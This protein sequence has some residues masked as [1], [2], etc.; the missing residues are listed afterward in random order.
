MLNRIIDMFTNLLETTGLARLDPSLSTVVSILTIAAALISAVKLGIRRLRIDTRQKPVGRLYD[1]LYGHSV[2]SNSEVQYQFLSYIPPRFDEQKTLREL[3]REIKQCSGDTRSKAEVF[4]V[5]GDPACGKTTTMRYL[6]C[7]LS[8]SRKCVYFQMQGVAD[9]ESLSAYL[10]KQKEKNNI[11]DG[12]SVIAFFD[13]LDEA[14]AFFQKEDPDSMEK[15]FQSIFFLGPDSKIDEAFQKNALNLDCAVVSLRPEFLERSKQSLTELQYKNIYSNVYKILPLS[16]R[17]VIKI[18]KSLWILKII[19]AYNKEPE[20]RHQNLYPAWWKTPYYTWLLRR[21]LRNNP[22]CLFHY[23]MYIRYAY[24]FMQDY[25]ERESIGNRR[26]FSNNIAVSF[27]ILL[28]AIIKWEFHIYFEDKFAKKNQK[29]LDQFKQKIEACS[30]A[31]VLQLLENGTPSLS[32]KQFQEIVGRFFGDELSRLA[33]AHCFMVSDDKGDNFDFCHRMFYEYFLAKHLFE[34]ADYH[35][36]KDLLYS[37]DA[38]DYLRAMYYSIL[39]RTG[40]LNDRIIG[41]AKYPLS[42]G[43]LTL[44]KCQS[45]EK[46]GWISIHDE[47]HISLVEILEYLPCINSFQYRDQDFTR[48]VLED[49]IDRGNLDLSKTGWNYLRYVAGVTPLERIKT[50]NINGLPLCDVDTL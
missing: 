39:C 24:A 46:E 14:Y 32:R 10:K 26:A 15:A 36:R 1:A 9:M 6:Y 21:I 13:G 25:K 44:S 16:N 45:L 4:S 11:E 5:I 42:K 2:V 35:R 3:M 28:N 19:E 47:P 22:D 49:L 38:S 27:D 8:K 20:L 33:M 43:N 31:I 29:E 50:L 40:E 23:P 12:S 37:A 18:F 34:K 30:E 48:E 41:S 17:D 7:K